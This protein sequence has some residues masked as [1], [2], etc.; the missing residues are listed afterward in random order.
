MKTLILGATAA[1]ATLAA[2][3]TASAQSY[4]YHRD[5]QAYGYSQDYGRSYNR[6]Y[7]QDYGRGYDRSAYR[8][9]DRDGVPDRY[10]RYDNRY[11]RGNGY[12]YG[13]WRRHHHHE[14]RE[15]YDRW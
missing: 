1:V 12:G 3:G 7:A 6:G 4:G 10:D 9:R 5:Y 11:D 14:W 15:R 2:A 8:D 13:H